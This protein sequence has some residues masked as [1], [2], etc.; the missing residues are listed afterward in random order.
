MLR[1]YH[2]LKKAHPGALLFFRLGDFYEMFFD[3]AI[4]GARELE[5]TLTARNKE[6]G[7]P[8]PMCGVPYHAAETYVARLIRKGYRVAICDQ[9]EDPRAGKLVRRE[10]VRVV[11]PGTALEGQL[12]TSAENNFLASVHATARGAGLALL[13]LSTGEFLATE[14]TG[15]GALERALDEALNH[16][17]RELL[18]PASLGEEVNRPSLPWT[19]TSL[20]DWVY[21]SEYAAGVIISHFEVASLDGFGLSGHDRAVAAA[22]SLLHYA[23]ETQKSAITHLQG[24]TWFESSDALSLDATTVRNLE[25]LMGLDGSRKHSLLAV[26]DQTCTAMG[27][28]LLR[29]QLLRPSV[30]L[31]ELEARLDAV[32]TLRAATIPR[33][34]LRTALGRVQDL[35][36]LCA[37]IAMGRA[38]AR[39]LV[40]LRRSLERL[41]DLR[42]ELAGLSGALLAA[43]HDSCEDLAD[44]RDLI[45]AAI[46]DDPPIALADG[47]TV[48]A[49]YNA[50]LD[51]VREIASTS[52]QYIAALEQRERQST[53]IATLKVR[54]N[55]V[56]GYYI[57]VSRANVRSVPAHYERR[58]TMA[59]AERYTIPELKEYE[60]RVRGADETALALETAIFAEVRSGV[61]AQTQRIQ[62]VAR[63]IARID[64]LAGLAEVAARRHYCRPVLTDGDEILIRNGRH[65]I[66]ETGPEPFIPN[67]LYLNGST[68]RLLVVT[69][70]NMGG[71]SVYLRQ[72]ALIVILAQIGAYVPA[73][74]ARIGLVDRVYTRVGASDSLAAGRSTF[75]V[76][77]TE[78]ANILNTAT[79]RSLVLL[80]EVGRGTATFDGLSLAWAIAEYLH[81]NPRHT[82]RT[83]FA[84]HYH[85]L[86]ELARVLPGVR[87]Y[88]MA[89]QEQ[90]GQILFVRKVVEGAASKSYGIEVARLAG[91]PA[92]VIARAREIVANL[93]A[94]ELDVTGKPKLARHLPARR[95]LNQPTLFDAANEQVLDELRNLDTAELS[96]D[97]AL[98]VL[99][100]LRSRLL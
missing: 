41:P 47:G 23:H 12:L 71:K 89:V 64:V 59:N 46:A 9:V 88:Q 50:E 32:T 98:A 96:A 68:D 20:D 29:Q 58:Q 13:D 57:E 76:E 97:R 15:D 1:Q 87:N 52:K 19:L 39:D 7:E 81:D 51:S 16:D 75:M 62:E 3:D 25:L 17:V 54:F 34:R 61:A 30:S 31:D 56:F 74:E 27:A 8:I 60:A 44:V 90:R 4:I 70:P 42:A 77:M 5:I 66:V 40:A 94:N 67:D 38:N 65:A 11:T 43:L 28:R 78:T 80:D 84:T 21:A 49:G 37:R 73:S 35:E 100:A 48:R 91:L 55:N 92:S 85:E 33:D 69:G 95:H 24:L 72:A 63:A 36:R 83:V 22:G 86:T 82:A 79:P 93:E 99:E 26:V 6:I 45:A 53:G 10:V 14:F 18:A 2:E